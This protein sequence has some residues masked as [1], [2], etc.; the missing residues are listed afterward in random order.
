MGS[1]SAGHVCHAAA[2]HALRKPREPRD[3]VP[4]AVPRVRGAGAQGARAGDRG[5]EHAAHSASDTVAGSDT[6]DTVPGS[7]T[8]DTVAS[9]DTADTVASSDTG[10][11]ECSTVPV[12]VA[13]VVMVAGRGSL[14]R[15]AAAGR[16]LV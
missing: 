13:G 3:G 6:G 5:A 14:G 16:P 11:G 7:D 10:G 2:R 4:R 1:C 8:G 15:L 12:S 9:S